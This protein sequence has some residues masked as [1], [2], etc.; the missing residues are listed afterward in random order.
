[1]IQEPIIAWN[2]EEVWSVYTKA[3][4]NWTHLTEGFVGRG[5]SHF[6]RADLALVALSDRKIFNNF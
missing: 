1:M 2:F 6:G 5:F 3:L 4:S